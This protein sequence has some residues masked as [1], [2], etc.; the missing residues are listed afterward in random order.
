M[1][2]NIKNITDFALCSGCGAC[3]GVCKV[4]AI[5]M[6]RN[7]AGFLYANVDTDKCVE[8]GLCLHVCT[9]NHDDNNN[10]EYENEMCKKLMTAYIGYSTNALIR[11]Q[12]QSGGVVTEILCYLVEN[13]KVDGVIITKY[14]EKSQDTRALFSDDI[15]EIKEAAG[16]H[17]TQ[18]NVVE[19]I[20]KHSDKKLAVVVIGCQA[21]AIH[22]LVEKKIIMRPQYII[23]LVCE[24]QFSLN[25]IDEFS[26]GK[27]IKYYR[28]RDKR[29]GGWPGNV[30]IIKKNGIEKDFDK[31]ERYLINDYYQNYRC[32]QCPDMNNIYSDCVCGDPWHLLVEQGI[33]K[34]KQGYTVIVARN[35][36]V[37]AIINDAVSKGYIAIEQI[38]PKDFFDE[39]IIK[40]NCYGRAYVAQSTAE[41][42]GLPRLFKNKLQPIIKI[43]DE[44]INQWYRRWSQHSYRNYLSKSRKE[45]NVYIKKEKVHD[46]KKIMKH[47]V[48][49]ATKRIISALRGT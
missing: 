1:N 15:K 26:Y 40:Y 10:V 27:P 30:R 4:Q 43:E 33:E 17:Y 46:L 5:K 44:S 13:K 2:K 38:E 12:G 29:A 11:Q 41:E 45:S 21:Q 9:V 47:K 20:I 49:T 7:P 6:E 32:L 34:L 37:N 36:K 35:K 31:K 14:D 48:K 42:L 16:S 23:G 19:E 3:A 18:S 24:R 28:A 39:N 22:L 25:I 8:C